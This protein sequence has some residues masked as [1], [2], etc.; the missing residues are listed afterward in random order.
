[1]PST[2]SL[3]FLSLSGFLKSTLVYGAAIGKGEVSLPIK[4]MYLTILN[5]KKSR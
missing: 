2:V 1:M 5:N 4:Y 3:L